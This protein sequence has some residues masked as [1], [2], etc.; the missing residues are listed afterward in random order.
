M[1]KNKVLYI[2][3]LLLSLS[4]MYRHDGMP[5]LFYKFYVHETDFKSLENQ[6]L[7]DNLDS[8]N[9]SY[10]LGNT[11]ALF[12]QT[13]GIT[14]SHMSFTPLSRT[15]KCNQIEIVTGSK[16]SSGYTYYADENVLDTVIYYANQLS[17]IDHSINVK[18]CKL[19]EHWMCYNCSQEAPI[20]ILIRN[21]FN[22]SD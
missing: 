22:W 4:C 19:S 5:Y 18:I 15:T 2:I 7:C 6:F 9:D 17:S 12:E 20:A 16:L 8:I 13:T 3:I 1:E 11:R 14:V 21:K 10:Q